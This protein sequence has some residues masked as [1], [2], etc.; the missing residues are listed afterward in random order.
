LK[1][2]ARNFIP[3]DVKIELAGMRIQAVKLKNFHTHTSF[4]ELGF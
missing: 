3:A 4:R 1:T 2:P